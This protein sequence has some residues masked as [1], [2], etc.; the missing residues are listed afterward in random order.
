ME[1]KAPFPIRA[2]GTRASPG[3]DRDQ[4]GGEVQGFLYCHLHRDRPHQ[5]QVGQEQAAMGQYCPARCGATL[6]SHGV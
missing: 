4:A 3:C 2:L 5:E 1:N 6:S